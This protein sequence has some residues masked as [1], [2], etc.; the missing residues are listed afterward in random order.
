MISPKFYFKNKPCCP[1]EIKIAA[2]A[3]PARSRIDRSFLR[4]LLNSAGLSSL[5]TFIGM[6]PVLL[7]D[8][9]DILWETKTLSCELKFEIDADCPAKTLRMIFERFADFEQEARKFQILPRVKLSLLINLNGKCSLN[10]FKRIRGKLQAQGVGGFALLHYA[11]PGDLILIRKV[12]AQLQLKNDPLIVYSRVM[13]K[14]LVRT[15]VQNNNVFTFHDGLNRR[16]YG[17]LEKNLKIGCGAGKKRLFILSDGT[18]YPCYGA[19]LQAKPM[20]IAHAGQL[21]G[22]IGRYVLPKVSEKCRGCKKSADCEKCRFMPPA[23]EK[24]LCKAGR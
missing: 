6:P 22:M 8:M 20:G 9:L 15:L 3:D 11:G 4:H 14:D 24:I 2:S 23:V 5:F 19:F 10:K 21:A 16:C 18:V 7:K 12:C 17:R 1:Q 13:D